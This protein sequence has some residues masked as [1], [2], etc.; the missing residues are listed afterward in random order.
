MFRKGGFVLYFYIYLFPVQDPAEGQYDQYIEQG[1]TQGG[2][3]GRK[4]GRKEGL[5]EPPFQGHT[6][7][8]LDGIEQGSKDPG[9]DVGKERIHTKYLE[10]LDPACVFFGINQPIDRAEQQQG[11]ATGEQDK[12]TGPEFLVEGE[13]HIPNESHDEQKGASDH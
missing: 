9:E 4:P 11:Y 5:V 3:F 2:I 13:L 12:G 6:A 10:G 8:P 7:R 1:K